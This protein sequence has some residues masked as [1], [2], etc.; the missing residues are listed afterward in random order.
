MERRKFEQLGKITAGA[1]LALGG[2]ATEGCTQA[3]KSIS[4]RVES[5][6]LPA[7]P[8][9]AMHEL[10]QCTSEGSPSNAVSAEIGT[11][12]VQK[13]IAT[14][15]NLA[16]QDL[17][18]TSLLVKV[19]CAQVIDARTYPKITVT[20]LA[21]SYSEEGHCALV[22]VSNMAVSTTDNIAECVETAK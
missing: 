7:A 1:I 16:P 20:N 15:F 21:G 5:S 3:P 14:S 6:T 10:L 8:P 17:I 12:D 9:S 22:P 4:A 19:A 11:Q 2:L 13:D 18:G